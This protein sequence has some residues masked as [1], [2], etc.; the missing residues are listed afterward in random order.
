MNVHE[1]QERT[2]IEAAKLYYIE[3][4]SQKDIATT[5]N[6][7]RATVSRLLNKA[8]KSGIVTITI[9]DPQTRVPEIANRIRNK[10]NLK[11]VY[12]AETARERD[13]TRK[14]V[15]D[16]TANILEDIFV[17]NMYLGVARGAITYYTARSIVNQHNY[18]VDLVQMVGSGFD[19]VSNIEG[20][21]LMLRF[22]QKTLGNCHVLNA[23]IMVRNRQT[24]DTLIEEDSIRKTMNLYR[25]LG[26]GLFKID[27]VRSNL[28]YQL[29]DPWITRAD[30]LQ[31]RELS[32]VGSICGL[33][34]DK[35]GQCC[36]A[37]INDRRIG[38]A[39]EEI[40]K[41]PLAIGMTCGDNMS[42]ATDAV[43]KSGLLNALIIDEELAMSL[44]ANI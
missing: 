12:I 18:R 27:N 40:R 39:M 28:S 3:G 38:I 16:L 13:I 24:R 23:P 44:I 6:V 9:K 30:A 25:L 17:Q 35:H 21:R 22:Q 5:I 8:I 14:N 42:A 19:C 29:C 41:I 31:L 34:F 36:S 11:A 26:V 37:G 33:Y 4:Y 43:L 32:A 1:N 2:I 7:S 10:Y 20:A 15:G